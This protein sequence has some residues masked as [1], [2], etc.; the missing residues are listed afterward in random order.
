V[1]SPQ[2]RDPPAADPGEHEDREEQRGHEGAKARVLAPQPLDVFEEREER[3]TI[4]RGALV[5][6]IHGPTSSIPAREHGHEA[7]MN[8]S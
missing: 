1:S 8:V 5:D 6:G 4:G 2:D 3:V 7:R